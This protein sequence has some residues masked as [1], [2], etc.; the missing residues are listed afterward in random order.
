MLLEGLLCSLEARYYLQT[1]HSCC[2]AEAE[3][4]SYLL[5]PLQRESVV[6]RAALPGELPVELGRAKR[7]LRG[8]ADTLGALH[9]HL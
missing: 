8:S 2:L 7:L 9:T 6:A 5:G 3:A 4:A 1:S